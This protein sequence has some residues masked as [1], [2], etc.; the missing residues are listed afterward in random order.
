[1]YRSYENPRELERNVDRIKDMYAMCSD[2]TER[3]FIEEE[4]YEAKQRA[5]WAW[6]DEQ[7][8]MEGE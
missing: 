2:P 3:G 6:L 1:M 7:A 8:D 4:L 5:L